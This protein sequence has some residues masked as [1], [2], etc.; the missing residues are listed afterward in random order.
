MGCRIDIES[1]ENIGIMELEGIVKRFPWFSYARHVLLVRLASLSEEIF[2]DQ[3]KSSAVFLSSRSALYRRLYERDKERTIQGRDGI[4]PSELSDK[5]EIA[6][7]EQAIDAQ[8]IFSPYGEDDS[9]EERRKTKYI[10]AGGDFFSKE[11]YNE[12]EEDEDEE[13]KLEDSPFFRH[14]QTRQIR[15]SM[16]TEDG[17]VNFEDLAFF[18]ETLGKIYSDQ[19]CYD[20]A[21]RVFSKLILLYPQKSAYFAALINQVRRS[22]EEENQKKR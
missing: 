15:T 22:R 1:F 16:L 14:E 3:L 20:E 12:I 8:E 13:K 18:T 11:D 10:V 4:A 9:P 7:P 6:E 19:G 21:E 2:E 5:E 17:K